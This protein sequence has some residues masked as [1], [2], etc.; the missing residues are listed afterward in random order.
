MDPNMRWR[1]TPGFLLCIEGGGISDVFPIQ[2]QQCT[3]EGSAGL[4]P[5][6]RGERLQT[7]TGQMVPVLRTKEDVRSSNVAEEL[8]CSK[9]FQGMEEAWNCF[10]E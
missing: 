6:Y 8:T 9:G 2:L 5:V 1:E 4:C 7:R 3:A 10:Y